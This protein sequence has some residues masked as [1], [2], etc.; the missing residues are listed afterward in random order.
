MNRRLQRQLFR[1]NDEILAIREVIQKTEAELSFH[2]HLNDDAQRDASVGG[3]LE[4]DEARETRK[5]VDRFRRLVADLNGKIGA[6]QAKR[7]ELLSRLD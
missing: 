3:P 1:I 5:D 7:A 2:E 6:L 4:R